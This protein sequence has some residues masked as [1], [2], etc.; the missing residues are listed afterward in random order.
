MKLDRRQKRAFARAYRRPRKTDL[1][2]RQEIARRYLRREA[3][4]LEL[5]LEYDVSQATIARCV[6]EYR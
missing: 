4:Q 2:M 5:A 3:K 6:A 1:A